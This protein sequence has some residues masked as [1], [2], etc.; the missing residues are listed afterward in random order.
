MSPIVT[1]KSER[2]LPAIEFFRQ[3]S[4][5]LSRFLMKEGVDKAALLNALKSSKASAFAKDL[6]DELSHHLGTSIASQA[7]LSAQLKSIARERGAL[8]N[9][10]SAFS[11]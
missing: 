10:K 9:F 7:H 11:A 2:D 4:A 8:G 1:V 3:H 5:E 6:S